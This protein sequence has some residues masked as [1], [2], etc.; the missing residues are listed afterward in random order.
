LTAIAGVLAEFVAALG[1]KDIGRL[2]ARVFEEIAVASAAGG[3]SLMR[4]IS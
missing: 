4:T 3:R 2:K 1:P